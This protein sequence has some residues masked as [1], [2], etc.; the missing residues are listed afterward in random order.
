MNIL[1]IILSLIQLI[2]ITKCSKPFKI[3]IGLIYCDEIEL[4]RAE[5]TLIELNEEKNQNSKT[6]IRIEIKPL[7]LK[8]DDNPVS[9]SLSICENLMSNSFIYGV[10][11]SNSDCLTK[12]KND[13][14][15]YLLTLSAVSFTCSYYQ[16]PVLDLSSRNSIFSDKVKKNNF[17]TF[18]KYYKF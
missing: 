12:K 4:T 14:T 7:K 13:K 3:T 8:E 2:N 15:D 5:E 1:I 18:L 11:I 16:I 17:E 9:V 6:K 10:V